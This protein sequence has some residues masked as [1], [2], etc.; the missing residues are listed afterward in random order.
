MRRRW[1]VAALA[2]AAVVVFVPVAAHG[3]G[4]GWRHRAVCSGPPLGFA[5]CQA[6]VDV[7]DRGRTLH[8][9]TP[10]GLSP[11]SIKAA[12]GFP[13][14]NSAGAGKTIAIV[15]AYDD[16][17]AESDLAVFSA[18]FGLPDCT[19]ANGCFTK[20]NQNGGTSYPA[21]DTGWG[22]EIS[23]DI[24]WAHAIA[25]GAKILL[26][27]ASSNSFTNLLA[28][29]DYAKTHAQYVSN[30]W[31]GS[32]SPGETGY[33]SH[34]IQSGV[35]FFASSGDNGLPAEYP[36]SS[37]NV[38]SVG[39][40][41]LH[42]DGNGNFTGE[43]G[44]AEG[45][46]GCSVYETATSAQASF[47][48]YGQAGCGGRRATPDV[49]LDA[50]PNS[51]VSVYDSYGYGGWVIVGGTSA[52][53][54]MWAARSA[55]AGAIVNAA[56]VYAGSIP[57]RDIT[58]G[59]NGAPC[60]VGFDLCTGRG[61]WA[62]TG[63][64]PA[65]DFS[66]SASPSGRT[67]TQGSGTSYT[68]T[69]GQLNGFGG[70]V[71]L[72]ASGLPG[73][74][75]ASFSP[76]SATSSSTLT[77]TTAQNTPTGTYTLTITGTSGSLVHSTTVSLTVDAAAQ[78]GD[79]SLSVSPASRTVSLG[80]STSYTVTISPAGGPVS[81]SLGGQPNGVGYSFSPNPAS[82]GSSTLTIRTTRTRLGGATGTFTLTITGVSG[83]F[84]HSATV[85]LVI[86]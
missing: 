83:S 4:G 12:Y 55:D 80:S 46:G 84:V 1:L 33:D 54:P 74:A 27:E 43:T 60:L 26:V 76:Q 20:V 48:G 86:N 64:A 79:F 10:S 19:T 51:G 21:A 14:G 31:S 61:S 45:G 67:V 66:L 85:T 40:T 69:I 58:S 75:S 34:F 36:S 2:G 56:Y 71:A 22:L 24:Q 13:T 15:D 70:S 32:E 23:L 73:G 44:W 5:R 49:A 30:S 57:F 41:T 42:F 39:G 37:P 35:S 29:E 59:N 77:V 78:S 47:G 17:R 68:V 11:A 25:P 8:N 82:T 50:D 16:P 7:D 53:T 3:A 28:A 72:G 65:P 62:G 63:S 38:I 6:M 81:L 9:P 18:Q 52:A